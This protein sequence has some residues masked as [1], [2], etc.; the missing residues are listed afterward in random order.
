[1]ADGSAA[2]VAGGRVRRHAE[3][4]GPL[5][6]GGERRHIALCVSSRAGLAPRDCVTCDVLH[7]DVA[8]RLAREDEIDFGDAYKLKA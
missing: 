5:N 4:D 8:A 3:A 2:D 6:G 1:V 7:G